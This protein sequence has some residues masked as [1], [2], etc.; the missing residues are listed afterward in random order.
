MVT[1]IQPQDLASVDFSND[2]TDQSGGIKLKTDATSAAGLAIAAAMATVPSRINNQM[3]FSGTVDPDNT[4]PTNVDG[5]TFTTIAALMAASP[6][7]SFT[8]AYLAA[9]KTH[10][11]SGQ[12]PVLWRHIAFYKSGVGTNPVIQVT[13]FATA[14]HNNLNGFRF[15]SGGQIT[16][17]NCDIDLPTAKLDPVLPW[18]ATAALCGQTVAGF[19]TLNL[20]GVKITGGEGLG[21]MYSPGAVSILSTYGVILDGNVHLFNGTAA[22]VALLSRVNVSLLN[23]ASIASYSPAANIIIS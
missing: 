16:I 10:V 6:A 8:V 1:F 14:T 17:Q 4:S 19:Q 22:G 13:A 11:I 18:S 3:Y 12:I 15:A 2:G 21:M 9:G 23:G 5:G 20:W 7:G